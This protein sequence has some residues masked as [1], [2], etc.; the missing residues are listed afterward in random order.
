MFQFFIMMAT[1]IPVSAVIEPTDRS[2]PPIRMTKVMPM[3]MVK[4]MEICCRIFS[5]L[6]CF[7]K[8]GDAIA[9]MTHR[10]RKASKMPRIF[11]D[12]ILLLRERF[13]FIVSFPASD[14]A[15]PPV[16]RYISDSCVN[17]P[18]R[19]SPVMAP[20]HMTTIRS[21]MPMSS[22]ISEEITIT[23]LPAA[24]ISLIILYTSTFAP[25]SMPR[26][27][28]SRNRT[29]ASDISHLARTIFCWL[30]PERLTTFCRRDGVLICIFS[31]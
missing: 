3:A 25:M 31:T 13:I 7:K 12:L 4:L 20:R 24:A 18:L 5:R 16:A 23:H 28:S 6:V 29:F 2:M 14:S 26:V 10:T 22:V 15:L 30:P 17:C 21:Q 8:A 27:G 19:S 11:R 1:N 9:I